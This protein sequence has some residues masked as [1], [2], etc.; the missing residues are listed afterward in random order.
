MVYTNYAILGFGW[1]GRTDGINRK[2][3]TTGKMTHRIQEISFIFLVSLAVLASKRE[4][5]KTIAMNKHIK[6]FQS[7][8]IICIC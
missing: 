5:L 7:N 2:E 3:R 6:S 8:N 4:V 1:C